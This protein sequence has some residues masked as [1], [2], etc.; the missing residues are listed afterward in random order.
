MLL[1]QWK[2]YMCYTKN[3]LL[4][5]DSPPID[6]NPLHEASCSQ[7]KMMGRLVLQVHT[8]SI[9]LLHLHQAQTH[10]LPLMW[11]A[12]L[13]LLLVHLGH[14]HIRKR[15]E[16]KARNQIQLTPHYSKG[17]KKFAR[18]LRQTKTYIQ[19]SRPT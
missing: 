14:H 17:W 12:L 16:S 9:I 15:R 18:R 19:L 4:P 2:I 6:A 10:N 11:Q 7:Q 8:L 13:L 5:I 3:N 1:T